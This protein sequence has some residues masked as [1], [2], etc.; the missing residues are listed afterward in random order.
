MTYLVIAD[1]GNAIKQVQESVGFPHI[2]KSDGQLPGKLVR[3]CDSIG[4][5]R[6]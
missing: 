6:K 1:N 2:A 3:H 5:L 4:T